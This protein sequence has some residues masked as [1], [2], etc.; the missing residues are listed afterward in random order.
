MNYKR[1]NH[2]NCQR[3]VSSIKYVI[4]HTSRLLPLP[5]T[6]SV[7][8]HDQKAQ[9][10][11]WPDRRIRQHGQLLGR[12]GQVLESEHRTLSWLSHHFQPRRQI[13][14]KPP[15]FVRFEEARRWHDQHLR[16]FW[17]IRIEVDLCAW[18]CLHYHCFYL[19]RTGHH[20]W[21]G[22]APLK[23]EDSQGWSRQGH[24][25]ALPGYSKR[26]SNQNFYGY[27]RVIPHGR[28]KDP[29]TIPDRIRQWEG[30]FQ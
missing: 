21:G 5:R 13:W 27:S 28:L 24:Y 19:W 9:G 30:I 17:E 11:R 18:R 4:G 2:Y 12:H 20:K 22:K 25:Y 7:G 26:F 6:R 29:R 16:R 10:Y 1:N 3:F 8:L 23:N 14:G 15:P